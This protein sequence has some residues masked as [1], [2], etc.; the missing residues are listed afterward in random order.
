MNESLLPPLALAFAL[1]F[2][3]PFACGGKDGP[4]GGGESADDTADTAEPCV[5]TKA[6]EDCDTEED[7]D[8]GGSTND[9]DATGCIVFYYDE[10]GDGY[11]VVG[12]EGNCICR[13]EAPYQAYRTDDCDDA[14]VLIS[15]DCD[16][17]TD[18][19]DNDPEDVYVGWE[20][21][22]NWGAAA[23]FTCEGATSTCY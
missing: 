2:A 3:L 1:P 13:A 16:W 9:L 11:G 5:P 21:T 8:C 23:S 22:Y 18:T 14:N 15:Q 10:D 17:G 4:K 19:T 6:T 20:T 7:D 12:D